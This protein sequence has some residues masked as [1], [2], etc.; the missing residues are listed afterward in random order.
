MARTS[1]LLGALHAHKHHNHEVDRQAKLRRRAA[2]RTGSNILVSPGQSASGGEAFMTGAL[3]FDHHETARVGNRSCSNATPTGKAYSDHS[4][5]VSLN[6][7]SQVKQV[8]TQRVVTALSREDEDDADDGEHLQESSKDDQE[9]DIPLSEIANL[10]DTEEGDVIPHQRLTINNTSALSQAY[11]AIA[12]SIV[13]LPF[14]EH[15]IIVSAGPAEVPDVN[16]DLNRELVLHQQCLDA[17]RE[18][19]HLLKQEGAPFSRPSDYF[20]EMIKSDE[21]MGRIKQKLTEDAAGRKAAAEAKKQRDLKKFG[22]QVQVA[23][24]QERNK[25]KKDTLDKINILK[26]KRRSTDTGRAEEIDMFDIALED[27]DTTKKV[28]TPDTSRP[29]RRISAK[30]QKKDA[31]FGFGGKKRFA[32]SGDAFSTSDLR[33]FSAKRM[34]GRKQGAQRPGKSRR[35]RKL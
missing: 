31:K 12:V 6:E 15:H 13:K 5:G 14:S 34:K 2:K 23:K 1:K 9:E 19:R 22:K 18:A 16:D 20:A 3:P 4:P 11:N 35:A 30:R 25:A 24:L 26:R 8:P 32:K 10:S 21:Q 7:S 27:A 33:N 28:T 29:D 17:V